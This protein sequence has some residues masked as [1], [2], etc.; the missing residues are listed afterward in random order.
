V[1]ILG[2]P[3]PLAERFVRT[4]TLSCRDSFFHA[5][6]EMKHAS[7][8]LI[9]LFALSL[10]PLTVFSATPLSSPQRTWQG[11]PGVERT[12]KGRLFVSWFSGGPREPAP[13]NTVYL[14]YSDDQGTTFVTPEP[15][16]GPIGTSRAFDPTLWRDP[17][18]KLWYIFNRGDKETAKHGVY[19]RTCDTPDAA[20][21]L[22]SKEFRIG[23]AESPYS[24]RMN[25][26]TVLSNGAWIM[27][28]TH[29]VEPV[30]DWFAG[31]KQ[32]QGVGV[33]A[34]EGRTWTLHGA[35]KA[36]PWALE[37]M[38]TELRDGRLWMLIR[39]GSGQLWQSHSADHGQTWTAA[40][41]TTIANPGSRFFIRRLA[42][43]RLLLVNHYKFRGRSHLTAQCSA[44]DG[45]TW[46]EGLLLDER[47]NVSYPDGVQADDG[48][49][50]IVYDRDRQGAAEILMAT[51][52]EEDVVAGKDVSGRVR[53]R[54]MVNKLDKPAP[55]P[56]AGA[57]LP[58]PDGN[59]KQA[60]DNAMTR[61]QSR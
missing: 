32:L 7:L 35:I 51:F 20:T 1:Y 8:A 25:K 10:A 16:A 15:M 41:A 4:T 6:K 33:S 28:V 44:N 50:W 42:S 31:V 17:N 61:L 40:T 56:P 3:R 19:A 2:H 47:G 46:N 54:Q 52:R 34:D 23:Y 57:K 38:I 14:S 43:G 29:A 55:A 21:P 48:T 37:N 30:H 60:A 13:E 53:L 36:P 59:P 9:T 27:P 26:P 58:P 22:W 5:G 24:F 12:P 18:G 45:K 49:I 11:I 39:T